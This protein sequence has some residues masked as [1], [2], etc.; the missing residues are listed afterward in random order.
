M[1]SSENLNWQQELIDAFKLI[2]D[3]IPPEIEYRIYYDKKGNITRCS[4][5]EHINDNE[6]IVVDK[7][8]YD[9]YFRY[10][11]I[12]N[13]KLRKINYDPGYRVVL[14][15]STSGFKVVKNQAA[16]LIESNETYNDIEYY[17]NRDS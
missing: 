12:I 17:N 10:D 13:G 3:T 15:P 14:Y 11:K 7:E 4:M 6:Y 1:T 8:T 9:N 16:I 5:C 2:N